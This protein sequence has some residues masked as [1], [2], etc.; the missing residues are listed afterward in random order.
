M[1]EGVAINKFEGLALGL[2][3]AEPKLDLTHM[4]AREGREWGTGQVMEVT[5][6]LY[7]TLQVEGV[8][9]SPSRM[10]PGRFRGEE[11]GNTRTIHFGGHK[12]QSLQ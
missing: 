11:L 10:E 2:S 4:S 3:L 9:D 6:N 7:G 12:K 8:G 5:A 1:T